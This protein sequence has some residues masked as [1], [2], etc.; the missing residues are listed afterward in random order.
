VRWG[1]QYA[2]TGPK[3]TKSA[4]SPPPAPGATK[5]RASPPECDQKWSCT[6][7]A[8]EPL[9]GVGWTSGPS[10]AWASQIVPKRRRGAGDQ[11]WRL[12]ISRASRGAR[13]TPGSAGRM[14]I[15]NLF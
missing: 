6:T 12:R 14:S 4:T 9:G 3:K 10:R 1:E 15:S 5:A 7:M 2:H 8:Q 11:I 13:K